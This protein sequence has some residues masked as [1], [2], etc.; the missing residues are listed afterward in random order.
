MKQLTLILVGILFVLYSLNAA[1]PNVVSFQ[2]RLAGS[3]GDAVNG[4][5]SITFSLYDAETGGTALWSETQSSVEINDGLFQVAL[6]SITTLPNNL[7]D[8]SER[9]LGINVAGDGEMTPRTHIESVP[10]AKTDGDWTIDGNNISHETGKVGIG[11]TNPTSKLTLFGGDLEVRE[12]DNGNTAAKISAGNV[13]GT[14]T[15][16]HNGTET[17]KLSGNPSTKSYFNAGNVGIGTSTPDKKLSVIGTVRAANDEN[18]TEF[19]EIYHGGSNALINWDGVGNL[20]FRYQNNT[21]ATL[22]QDGNLGV[23]TTTPSTKL[24]VNGQ[25]SSNQTSE[26]WFNGYD[27][28]LDGSSANEATLKYYLHYGARFFR[29]VDSGTTT[30]YLPLNGLPQSVFGHQV[31]LVSVTIYYGTSQG[32]QVTSTKIY[33]NNDVIAQEILPHSSNTTFEHYTITADH[34]ISRNIFIV[35]DCSHAGIGYNQ[36][37]GIQKVKAIV[38]Y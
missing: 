34:N 8:G 27:L 22:T 28:V 36:S 33:D 11:T 7:F 29:N 20:D 18:E 5:L 21:K 13:A 30:A 25:I 24:E 9:W 31:K 4:T 1:V 6:G 26:Y 3:G 14:M 16:Y 17:I 15:L 32:C 23:G 35:F 2:G 37:V 10:Y 12:D 19:A 38:Q